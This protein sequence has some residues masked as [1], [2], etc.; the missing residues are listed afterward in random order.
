M[1]RHR[2]P[3]RSLDAAAR[4]ACGAL[5]ALCAACGGSSA[6][7]PGAQS[8]PGAPPPTGPAAAWKPG[9]A[10]TWQWQLR[11]TL[12]VAYDVKVYD[13]DLFD[14]PQATIASLQAAGRHVVCYFSAGSAE[15]W[16]PD[17]ARF[18]AAD[19]GNALSGWPGE[20]WLDTR[21]DNVRAV[22]RSRLDLAV[23][24]RCDG[25]EPDN[26]DGYANNPGFALDAGSQLDFN[27]FLASQ[28][29]ARG[30]AVGLKNDVDQIPDLVAGFDFAI[31]EQCHE[32]DECDAYAAFTS[33]GKAVFN[34]EYLQADVTDGVARAKLCSAARAANLRTLVLPLQLDDSFR[35]SCDA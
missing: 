17:Y 33:G 19:M 3:P 5:L 27:R 34:A 12:D 28:A 26:V 24:K 6:P 11:G 31:N 32:F 35:Y 8:G 20:R 10:D 18:L 1:N 15:D 29:H 2:L 13:V 30:L 16:R 21:S 14:T 7:D 4:A 9:V 22:M 23:S 25:V